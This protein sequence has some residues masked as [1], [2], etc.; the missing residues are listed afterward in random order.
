MKAELSEGEGGGVARFFSRKILVT[1]SQK[2]GLLNYK[3][4]IMG[5]RLRLSDYGETLIISIP[6]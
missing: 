4:R 2:E 3:I 6:L 5:I 1:K